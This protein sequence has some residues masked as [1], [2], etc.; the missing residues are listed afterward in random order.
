[1]KTV[2][3]LKQEIDKVII[4]AYTYQTNLSWPERLV[5]INHAVGIGAKLV[6]A[7]DK[8][9]IEEGEI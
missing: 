5:I 2:K 1:M 6:R 9:D 4:S 7:E 8:I 3:E